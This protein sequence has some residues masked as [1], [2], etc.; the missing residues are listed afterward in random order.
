MT[1]HGALNLSILSSP[2]ITLFSLDQAFLF[3]MLSVGLCFTIDS[4]NTWGIHLENWIF[5]LIN[6]CTQLISSPTNK[7]TFLGLRI[8]STLNAWWSLL[9]NSFLSLSSSLTHICSMVLLGAQHFKSFDLHIL[10]HQS[11][12]R[13]MYALNRW[14]HFSH[15]WLCLSFSSNSFKISMHHIIIISGKKLVFILNIFYFAPFRCA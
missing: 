13:L 4:L 5:W 7:L 10:C 1:L 15:P 9:N 3:T 6:V 12:Q 2:H 8:S 14:S 11:A